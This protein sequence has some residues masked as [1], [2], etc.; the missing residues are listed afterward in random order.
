MN[1]N[2]QKIKN[3]LIFYNYKKQYFMIKLNKDINFIMR[4][5][6]LKI[7]IKSMSGF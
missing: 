1:K 5:I 7:R 6:Y 4:I 3:M 2:Y